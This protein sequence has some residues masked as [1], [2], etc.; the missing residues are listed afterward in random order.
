MIKK[1]K[2]KNKKYFKFIENFKENFKIKNKK[3]SKSI[4]KFKENYKSK[5]NN[6]LDI[7]LIEDNKIKNFK[8][9]LIRAQNHFKRILNTK[10]IDLSKNSTLDRYIS[11]LDRK[12]INAKAKSYF[13]KIIDKYSKLNVSKFTDINF[14]DIKSF[15]IFNKIRN[16]TKLKIPLDKKIL[17]SSIYKI[18][19]NFRIVKIIEKSK[20]KKYFSSNFKKSNLGTTEL[21]KSKFNNKKLLLAIQEK[22][23]NNTFLSNLVNENSSQIEDI[24][25]YI[26]ALYYSDHY[27]FISKLWKSKE[28]I[29]NVERVIEL[30]IPAK[31]IGDDLVT[32]ADELIE[33]SLDSFEVLNLKNP[34]LLIVLSSSFFSIKSFK[35]DTEKELSEND[36]L[37]QS[38]SPYLPQDTLVNINKLNE[39]S[40]NAIFTRKS[41]IN[42]WV[43][44][45]KKINYPVIGITTPG[46]HQIEILRS[47][48]K[49]INSLEIIVDIELNSS[50]IF[51]CSKDYEFSSQKIPYG[52]TLYKRKELVESYFS[53]LIKSIQLITNN[54]KQDFPEKVYVTGFGLDDFDYLSEKLPYPFVRFSEL[55][56]TE[57]K[58]NKNESE[59]LLNKVC[60]S[61]LNTIL[62][63]TSKCL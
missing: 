52:S 50:T 42:S 43:N 16:L 45:L 54:S 9:K 10:I 6:F 55:N 39:N 25:E 57:Y 2:S 31:V 18:F 59:E 32:N 56:K 23:K 53:R 34:P 44:T 5:I 62:G 61:K 49:I 28:N 21:R 4:E 29:L 37:I 12:I 47:N 15:E 33:L 36:E 24:P 38:K 63:I 26:A 27:L 41:L 1:K 48:K 13:L 11:Y 40:I 30:P 22:I 8:S 20:Y 60:E 58:F 51:T 3:Y 19:P 14:S 17:N 7:T 46:P 35:N